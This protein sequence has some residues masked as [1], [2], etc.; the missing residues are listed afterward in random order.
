MWLINVSGAA[1]N[2]HQSRLSFGPIVDNETVAF[3][4][5]A[6]IECEDHGFSPQIG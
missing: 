2:Q 6:Y 3:A 1:V 5:A 4:S